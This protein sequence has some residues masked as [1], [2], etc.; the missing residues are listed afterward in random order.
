M[1]GV[2]IEPDLFLSVFLERLSLFRDQYDM[3]PSKQQE[4]VR[5]IFN[6]IKQGLFE[7]L[8]T[9]SIEQMYDKLNRE[10]KFQF[11]ST[12]ESER[13][14]FIQGK[15]V[16][17]AIHLTNFKTIPVFADEEQAKDENFVKEKFD[18][19]YEYFLS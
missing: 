2:Y 4:K 19:V 3:L 13:L 7:E 11:T 17:K 15:K 14:F 16:S 6:D 5:M 8:V 9:G 18:S 1:Q 10:E 12:L